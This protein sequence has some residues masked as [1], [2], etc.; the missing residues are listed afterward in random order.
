MLRAVPEKY[1]P[2]QDDQKRGAGGEV[3]QMQMV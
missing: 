1:L 3:P 2:G